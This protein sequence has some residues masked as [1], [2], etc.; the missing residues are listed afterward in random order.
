MTEHQPPAPLPQNLSIKASP[1]IGSKCTSAIVE[2]GYV[3]WPVVVA[4]A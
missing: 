3:G 4:G 1:A 2:E